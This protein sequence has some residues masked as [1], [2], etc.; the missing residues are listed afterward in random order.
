M[1]IPMTWSCQRFV[2]AMNGCWVVFV[3]GKNGSS[4]ITYGWHPHYKKSHLVGLGQV[5]VSSVECVTVS[6]GVTP[7]TI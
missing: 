7:G 6:V 5:P 2:L 4:S 3:A 1:S